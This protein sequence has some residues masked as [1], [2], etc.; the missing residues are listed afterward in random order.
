MPAGHAC[1]APPALR[2]ELIFARMRYPH[3]EVLRCAAMSAFAVRKLD[4]GQFDPAL[5]M[6][7]AG[8]KRL[9]LGDVFVSRSFRGSQPH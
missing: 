5:V 3:L 1:P 6:A 8:L 9:G 7:S 4:E 2:R